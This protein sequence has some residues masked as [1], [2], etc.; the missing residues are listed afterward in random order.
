MLDFRKLTFLP[1]ALTGWTTGW[2][3]IDFGSTSIKIV[4]LRKK[5]KDLECIL[6]TWFETP[7]L[8]NSSQLLLQTVEDDFPPAAVVTS[9]RWI[10]ID[11]DPQNSESLGEQ[12]QENS[13]RL[14]ASGVAYL[15]PDPSFRRTIQPKRIRI[16]PGLTS[17]LGN[18]L[19]QA[20]IEPRLIDSPP[21]TLSR[22]LTLIHDE[23]GPDTKAI[24]DWSASNPML[25]VQYKGMPQFS[26]VLDVGGSLQITTSLSERLNLSYAETLHY[27]KRIE[28]TKPLSSQGKR[29]NDS[30]TALLAPHIRQLAEE[31]SRSL[32]FLKLQCPSLLPNTLY[33]CGAAA[34]VPCLVEQLQAQLD[35][36]LQTWSLPTIDGHTL[37]PASAQA[38][39]LSAMEWTT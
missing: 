30:A 25:V 26:R 5:R 19:L 16:A 22:A 23:S 21:W 14:W 29:Q 35:I 2:L 39:A 38:A 11:Y 31:L 1:S 27:L 17:W 33:L 18:Q 9:N 32:H 15:I 37:G 6:D 10:E 7:A 34:A 13:S 12:F 20:G 8:E 28:T 4:Q 24:L 36:R 3:G